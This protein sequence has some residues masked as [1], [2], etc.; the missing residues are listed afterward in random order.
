MLQIGD[1]V[2]VTDKHNKDMSVTGV[3]VESESDFMWASIKTMND[4]RF[5]ADGDKYDVELI[6]RVEPEA[7]GSTITL[8]GIT[9][10]KWTNSGRWTNRW[11]SD[12]HGDTVSWSD[13]MELV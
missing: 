6:R 4:D 5:F 7:V 3:V 10:T 8:N 11:I 1:V 9:Y 13:L 12:T 2:R